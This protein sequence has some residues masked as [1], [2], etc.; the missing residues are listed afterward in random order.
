MKINKGRDQDNDEDIFSLYIVFIHLNHQLS[1]QLKQEVFFSQS[2]NTV[3]PK[4][5]KMIMLNNNK[6]KFQLFL[7]LLSS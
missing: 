1:I 3:N 7:F 2:T 5:W 6:S 4:E